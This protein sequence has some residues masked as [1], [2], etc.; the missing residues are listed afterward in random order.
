MVKQIGKMNPFNYGINNVFINNDNGVDTY[1]NGALGQ[2][3]N[4]PRLSDLDN[5]GD[6]DLIVGN[7]TGR[8]LY[9]TNT[10]N[11]THSNFEQK[12]GIK[13]PFFSIN[14]ESN[15]APTIVDLDQDN[16]LDLVIHHPPPCARS[17]PGCR[18]SSGPGFV[19]LS[20]TIEYYKNI[21]TSDSPVFVQQT[22]SENP[23]RS[24][25]GYGDGF[26]NV[27]AMSDLDNDGDMDAIVGRDSGS[28]AYLKNIG[29]PTVP[30]F[31]D[32]KGIDNPFNGINVGGTRECSEKRF[33]NCFLY[34]S[35]IVSSFLQ[36]QVV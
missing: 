27:I 25:A 36:V 18:S 16:K 9:F 11:S 33:G 1:G 29:S 21:G 30:L 14:V 12:F 7:Q 8:I 5:D 35:F 10:G 13:N 3:F 23:F 20:N 24:C 15:A 17:G 4:I 6:Y 2:G 32:Q 34:F 19:T 26:Y 28:L 31:S 22:N